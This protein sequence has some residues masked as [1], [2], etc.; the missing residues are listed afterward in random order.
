LH[1]RTD[2][3]GAIH[4]LEQAVQFVRAQV[5]AHADGDGARLLGRIDRATTREHKQMLCNEFREWAAHNRLVLAP[6]IGA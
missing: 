4:S 3:D 5:L 6:S 2:P 1:L